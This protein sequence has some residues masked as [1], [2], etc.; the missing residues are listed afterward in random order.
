MNQEYSVDGSSQNG[1]FSRTEWI[2]ESIVLE[3][4]LEIVRYQFFDIILNVL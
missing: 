4:Q 3:Q 2:C 1:L